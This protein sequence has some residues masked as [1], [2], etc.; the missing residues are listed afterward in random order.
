MDKLVYTAVFGEADDRR[1]RCGVGADVRPGAGRAAAG[2]HRACGPTPGR[3]LDMARAFLEIN[4]VRM[5]SRL[6][7]GIDVP[8]SLRTHPFPPVLLISVVEN[9]VTHGIEPKVGAGAPVHRRLAGDDLVQDRAQRIHVRARVERS[10][11][12][13]QVFPELSLDEVDDHADAD[14]I[15]DVVLLLIGLS[16]RPRTPRRSP[17]TGWCSRS[18]PRSLASTSSAPRSRPPRPRQRK[19]RPPRARQG[20]GRRCRRRW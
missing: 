19:Q 11:R 4:R 15:E 12:R 18:R 1:F 10:A 6:D 2:E 8:D 14:Q 20:Q 9:A 16:A 3:E 5:G 7:F 13:P 17:R